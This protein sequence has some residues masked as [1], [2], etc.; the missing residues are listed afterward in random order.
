MLIFEGE[1]TTRNLFRCFHTHHDWAK[2]IT[3]FTC[4]I[5]PQRRNPRHIPLHF[6]RCVSQPSQFEDRPQNGAH[7]WL[8]WSILKRRRRRK[9][10]NLK[11]SR[12]S[13]QKYHVAPYVWTSLLTN[14]PHRLVQISKVHAARPRSICTSFASDRVAPSFL[15]RA[16]AYTHV[17]H[18][19]DRRILRWVSLEKS[20]SSEPSRG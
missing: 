2:K 3:I 20:P 8:R 17:Q 16:A 6:P 7:I 15:A 10:R 18:A 5:S 4:A 12:R 14:R 19:R 9:N 1:T 13:P 11:Y